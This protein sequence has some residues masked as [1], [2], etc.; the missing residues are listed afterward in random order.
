MPAVEPIKDKNIVSKMIRHLEKRYTRRD[1]MLFRIGINSTL[2]IS[3][4]I[5]IRFSDVFFDNGNFR[6]RLSITEKKTGKYKNVALNPKLRRYIKDYCRHYD[7]KGDEWLFFSFIRPHL[8]LDRI[9]AWSR[10]KKAATEVGIQNFGT[11][12]M[13]KTMAYH[14]Y[15]ETKDIALVMRLLNHSKPSYTM[16]YIG[17]EQQ[18]IDNVFK[19]HY[20][21]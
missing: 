3:D 9:T 18:A 2:R 14:V 20:F 4:I 12:S 5:N 11:H 15:N 13:R 21:A 6:P 17:L 16:R 8:P 10:L 7:I 1:A 19:E